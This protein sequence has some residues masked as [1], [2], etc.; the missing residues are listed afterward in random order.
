[1][2]N[3]QSSKSDNKLNIDY[4]ECPICGKT[5]KRIYKH[6]KK[7]HNLTVKEFKE[8]YPNNETTCLKLRNSIREN[9]KKSLNEPDVVAKRKLFR[10]SP[11]G[12][13][14]ASK[15]GAMAW[16]KEGFANRHNE[17]VRISSTRNWNNKE[18][19]DKV[20]VSIK[21]S[22][23]T[24]RVKKMHH[25]RLVKQWKDESYRNKMTTLACNMAKDGK[26]GR[27]KFYTDNLGNSVVMRSSWELELHNI[28]N[29]LCIHHEYEKY[30]FKYLYNNTERIYIPDFYLPEYNLFLEVKPKCFQTYEINIAKISSVINNGYLIRYIG[31]NEYNNTDYILNLISDL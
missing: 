28:L 14:M 25:D 15:N 4:V 19:R 17:A 8:L 22:L 3:Q 9:T 2:D 23:N 12:R 6:I 24:D 20:S 18:F 30:T 16:K 29:L 21:N 7:C 26:I 27:R 5:G 13:K 1:M 31:E 11:E 10:N